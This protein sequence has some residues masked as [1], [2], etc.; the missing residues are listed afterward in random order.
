MLF[1]WQAQIVA[2]VSNADARR[3]S[4]TAAWK[5]IQQI[6]W[7]RQMVT[8]RGLILAPS[9]AEQT[10]AEAAKLG[11]EV[12]YK[13]APDD[14]EGI[15][16][17]NHERLHLFS[18]S[19]FDAIVL[20]ESS[21]LKS[22]DGKIRTRLLKR[23][24]HHSASPVLHG[25]ACAQRSGRTRQPCRV[26]WR[27]VAARNACDVF[28]TRFRE[29]RRPWMAAQSRARQDF[30]RWVAQWA[31]YIRKPSD[32]GFDDGGF[33]LP[34]LRH[35]GRCTKRTSFPKGTC[36]LGWSVVSRDA[37]KRGATMTRE[38]DGGNDW[39]LFRA[40]ACLVRVKRGRSSAQS[41]WGKSG[42]H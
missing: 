18:P 7:I 13:E 3:S 2:G 9:V 5:T 35:G 28:Q 21:I 33:V 26:P 6:E 34:P 32:L 36:S 14:S 31:V 4:R 23:V 40:M 25:N 1:D 30:W 27:D 11:V 22:L 10:I 24:C 39:R 15:W 42:G 38:K 12:T 20:D 37:R 17:T 19:L 16:I 29:Q 8:T 41:C